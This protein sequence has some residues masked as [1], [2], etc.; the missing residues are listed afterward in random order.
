MKDDGYKQFPSGIEDQQGIEIKEGDWVLCGASVFLICFGEYDLGEDDYGDPT[1]GTGF[2]LV[3]DIDKPRC[4]LRSKNKLI[5]LGDVYTHPTTAD[6]PKELK[7]LVKNQRE[8]LQH[9]E[10][11]RLERLL[12]SCCVG[13][14]VASDIFSDEFTQIDGLDGENPKITRLTR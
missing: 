6:L 8:L 9:R 11:E 2:Y 10:E 14:I 4:E 5:I 13:S 7:E 1:G 3:N 12:S